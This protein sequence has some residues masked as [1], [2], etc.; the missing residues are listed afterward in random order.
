MH[1]GLAAAG[2]CAPTYTAASDAAA[3]LARYQA[4]LP[5]QAA[6]LEKLRE[7][8][9]GRRA[10]EAAAR[11]VKAAAAA[12]GEGAGGGGGARVIAPPALSRVLVPF[13][14]A[15]FDRVN[16][17]RFAPPSSLAATVICGRDW[18]AIRALMLTRCSTPTV[19]PT[20]TRRARSTTSS[21]AAW[22]CPPF[23]PTAAPTSPA[24]SCPWCRR[25]C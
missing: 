2:A 7:R 10:A 19:G 21:R 13:L 18:L 14:L 11:A 9:E 1:A 6:L 20:P 8:G 17:I 22:P 16:V 23:L 4:A 25:R 5:I 12:A 15:V 3:D 24:T